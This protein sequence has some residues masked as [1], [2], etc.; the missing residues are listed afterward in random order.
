MIERL[1]KVITLNRGITD[2]YDLEIIPLVRLALKVADSTEGKYDPTIYPVTEAWGMYDNK[3]QIPSKDVINNVI[4]KV[5]WK[6]IKIWDNKII[7]PDGMG[8]DFGGVGKGWI[9]DKVVKF[10]KANGVME[11]IVDAGGDLWVWGD[12]LWKVGIKN[13]YKDGITAIIKVKNKAVATSGGYENYYA[14]KGKKFHHI[15]N[16]ESGYPAENKNQSITVIADSC[17]MADGMATGLFIA[18][19]EGLS[20]AEQIGVKCIMISKN[21]NY[22]SGGVDI[23]W[24]NHD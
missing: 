3:W 19:E 24:I 9:V 2:E 14:Y 21:N 17:A 5:N 10:L 12:R 23:T 4:K 11:G 13:P 7:V 8:F 18:G 16:P 1:E 6:K 15:I 22:I 20:K